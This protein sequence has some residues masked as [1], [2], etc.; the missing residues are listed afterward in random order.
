MNFDFLFLSEVLMGSFNTGVGTID[1][2]SLVVADE[3]LWLIEGL[4]VVIVLVKQ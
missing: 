1:E 2:V 4:H 3:H